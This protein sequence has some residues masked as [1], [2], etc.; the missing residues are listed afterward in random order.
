VIRPLA[1]LLGVDGR[2]HSTLVRLFGTLFKRAGTNAIRRGT[3]SKATGIGW[4]WVIYLF[5][6]LLASTVAWVPNISRF[7]YGTIAAAT[8]FVLLGLAIVADFAV[9]VVAPGDDDVLFPLP[10][11]SRTY[12]AARLSFAARHVAGIAL[13]FGLPPALSGVARWREPLWGP[14]FLV[15]I[16]CTAWFALVVTF[17]VYRA[18]LRWLGG[19][20]LRSL[21]AFMPGL[22]SVLLYLG[23]QMLPRE[24]VSST[25]A[26][27]EEWLW[28]APPA[29]FAAVPEAVL[30][31]AG[32]VAAW[33]ALL[34]LVVLPLSA[35]L[36]IW[37]LGRGF[38]D[39]LRRMLSGTAAG[40]AGAG[41]RP[42]RP[43]P[44]SALVRA[45]FGLSTEDARAGYLLHL[46][47]SRSREARTRMLPLLLMPIV[48]MLIGTVSTRGTGTGVFAPY[49][50]GASAGTLWTL[51][52]YHETP[53]AAWVL[54]ALPVRRYGQVVLGV[55]ASIVVRFV[56][57]VGLLVVA[58]SAWRSPTP[59]GI[60]GATHGFLGSL[61]TLPLIVSGMKHVP[62]TRPYRGVEGRKGMGAAM[63][64][65]LVS[66]LAGAAHFFLART[67]PW[68]LLATS[69]LFAAA[70]LLWLRGLAAD[71]DAAPPDDLLPART[72]A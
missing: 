35:G 10:I 60:F 49:M 27:V 32:G 48:F 4:V 56:L 26:F 50:A 18:A 69:V 57:P 68:A 64:G 41:T 19:D 58:L 24:A 51:A 9:L 31:R 1:A 45:L 36:L 5:Y 33:C 20:R 2:A 70:T 30:G 72:A 15:S 29:W 59:A 7:A 65:V 17:A 12:L 11:D 53:D 46:G 23:P 44:P 8:G 16:L 14:L 25:P 22:I 3:S 13:A 52:A 42:A 71:L 40:R 43:L 54:S 34:G 28:A 6:G 47:A 38:L 21:V 39:D 66:L 37:A 62:F 55:V 61:L 63:L 67:M